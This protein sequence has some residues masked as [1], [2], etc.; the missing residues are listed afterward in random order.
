VKGFYTSYL[1]STGETSRGIVARQPGPYWVRVQL[2]GGCSGVS[3][4]VIIKGTGESRPLLH[5]SATTICSNDSVTLTLSDAGVSRRWSNGSTQS[6]ITVNMSD[7]YWAEVTL[8]SGCVYLTD[9]V[10]I[11]VL[12]APVRPYI[13][14]YQDT[15]STVPAL[16][17]QWYHEM[18]PI[19]GATQWKHALRAT[20]T[21]HVR[22][23]NA[24]GCSALSLEYKVD[25]LTSVDHA[26]PEKE[27]LLLY[28][29]P[30]QDY[31]HV[32]VVAPLPG[33]L[34]YCVRDMLGR[35]WLRDHIMVTNGASPL[36]LDI[37][38]LPQGVYTLEVERSGWKRVKVF[39][40]N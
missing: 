2:D 21:Y 26:A 16:S 31:L 13:T 18:L 25:A 32:H 1:W 30:A 14:R 11:S 23:G 40:R 34:R 33:P 10:R 39:V 8:P 27:F 20:G 6:S 35:V 22:I 7:Q 37:R 12:A 3:D 17:Y 9:T 15:L 5:A 28:P 38:P 19:P 24:Q 29:Q 36:S 4:T